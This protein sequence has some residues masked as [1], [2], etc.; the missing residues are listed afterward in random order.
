MLSQTI[1]N[2]FLCVTYDLDDT[3]FPSSH[4][5][6]LD[7]PTG[8]TERRAAPAS[9]ARRARPAAAV[10]PPILRASEAL[11]SELV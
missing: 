1:F 2:A 10:L 6:R 9:H 4:R 8:R 7:P 11:A 5:L 3:L